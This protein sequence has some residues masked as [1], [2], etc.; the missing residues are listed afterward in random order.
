M[1]AWTIDDISSQEEE[2]G[3]E[4]RSEGK[5]SEL[6]EIGHRTGDWIKYVQ[7]VATCNCERNHKESNNFYIVSKT[8]N[9]HQVLQY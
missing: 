7:S 2:D 1:R 6:Q 5:N 4:E 3:D 8:W 9:K